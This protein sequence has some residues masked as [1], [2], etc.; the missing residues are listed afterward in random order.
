[1]IMITIIIIRRIKIKPNE[2]ES[3]KVTHD[4]LLTHLLVLTHCPA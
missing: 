3:I 1:M 2:N 4:K